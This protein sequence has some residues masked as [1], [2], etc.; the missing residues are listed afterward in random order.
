MDLETGKNRRGKGSK[1]G[2][3]GF[4]NIVAHL[5][6][7]SSPL[8]SESIMLGQ[9]PHNLCCLLTVL[10]QPLQGNPLH[11][12]TYPGAERSTPTTK[13]GSAPSERLASRRDPWAGAL[14][15]AWSR[16][17]FAFE[18]R[19]CCRTLLTVPLLIDSFIS[20]KQLKQPLFLRLT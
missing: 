6:F 12:S 16:C 3:E 15:S 4:Y 9:G 10:S 14:L 19:T 8:S 7:R 13:P 1:R 17:S 5:P 11:G 18:P 20:A 2:Q